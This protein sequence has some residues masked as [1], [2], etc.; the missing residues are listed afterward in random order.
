MLEIIQWI[1]VFC[2]SAIVIGFTV[3]ILSVMYQVIKE[4]MND[5][6]H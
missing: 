6:H 4:E 3:M 1:A 5:E 2:V